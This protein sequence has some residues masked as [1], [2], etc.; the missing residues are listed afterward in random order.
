MTGKGVV[1]RI[2]KLL[3]TQYHLN[4]Q[5]FFS[6]SLCINIY[7]GKKEI[8]VDSFGNLRPYFGSVLSKA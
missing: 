8:F 4:S 6:N 2:L 5:R 3:S 1:P 7:T